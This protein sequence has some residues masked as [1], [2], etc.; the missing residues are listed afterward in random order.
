MKSHGVWPSEVDF[1]TQHN[2][3][4]ITHVATCI[5]GPFSFTAEQNSMGW[6]DDSLSKP[7]T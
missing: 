4:R 5:R 2:A 1:F 7:V 6:M 3:F